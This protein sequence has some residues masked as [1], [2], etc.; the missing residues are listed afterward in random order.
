MTNTDEMPLAAGRASLVYDHSSA[1]DGGA[2]RVEGGG[3]PRRSRW[4]VG[5]GLRRRFRG[6]GGVVTARPAA[7]LV[8]FRVAAPVG[9]EA[10]RVDPGS[11]P[12]SAWPRLRR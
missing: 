10:A 7:M 9:G 1:C 4:P 3:G 12:R 2:S 6:G 11:T 5:A 8:S